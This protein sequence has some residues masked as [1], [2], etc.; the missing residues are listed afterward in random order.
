MVKLDK[1]TKRFLI[2]Q[3]VIWGIILILKSIDWNVFG[4]IWDCPPTDFWVLPCELTPLGSF[5]RPCL[6]YLDDISQD[7]ALI[8][9]LY[10]IF[11]FAR[12]IARKIEKKIGIGGNPSKQG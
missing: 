9:I 5:I 6:S 7:L 3:I 11:F 8:S 4:I 2:I 10:S 12:I 1:R